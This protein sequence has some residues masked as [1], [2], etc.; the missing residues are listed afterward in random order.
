[1]RDLIWDF[2]TSL[3]VYRL[4][5]CPQ[6][7]A[8][9]HAWSDRISPC[10]TGFVTLDRPL[11][12]LPASK[13]EL[14]MV[15]D[16]PETPPHNN[17]SEKDIP[18]YVTQRKVS[19]GTRGDVGRDCRDAFSGL[20]A[21]CDKFRIALWDYLG[22]RFKMAGHIVVRPLDHYVRGRFPLAWPVA[23]TSYRCV[24]QCIDLALYFVDRCGSGAS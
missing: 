19:A 23:E 13:A 6:R 17:G 4:K 20:A 3:K 11:K 12:A 8:A 22:S 5:P 14:L 18:C 21:T 7:S 9:S 10:R 24:V 2:Y 15:R 1:L 16:R